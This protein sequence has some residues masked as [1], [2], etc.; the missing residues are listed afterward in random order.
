M[1]D[2]T[3]AHPPNAVVELAGSTRARHRLG[4]ALLL[5]FIGSGAIAGP[6]VPPHDPGVA[7]YR[8][9]MSECG[10]SSFAVALGGDL[11]FSFDPGRGGVNYIWRGAFVDLEPTWRA[12]INHP[13]E[14]RG[15]ILYRETVRY[16]LRLERA[17]RE[18]RFQFK[19][20]VMLPGAVEFHYLLDE[21]LVRE[22]IRATPDGH[23]LVRRFQVR[24]AVERWTYALEP[25]TTARI[26][27]VEGAWNEARTAL[28]GPRG[29][30]FSIRIELP[31][32]QP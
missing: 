31:V 30:E 10:P 11:G 25:Q 27:A 15:T 18:P 32:P 28:I 1:I 9:M 8:T 19:G 14:V 20:Y 7:V 17:G 26:S 12:K 16:P 4:A 23:G 2:P 3:P 5:L 29:R 22:E 24:E 6:A 13:A 21:T